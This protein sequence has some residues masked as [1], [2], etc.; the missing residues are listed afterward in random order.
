MITVILPAFNEQDSIAQ[1]VYRVRAVCDRAGLHDADI[2]VVDDGSSDE[3]LSDALNAGAIVVRH[4]HNLGYG[5]ALKA[6][7]LRSRHDTIVI[8][9]ADL[10]YPV[11]SLPELLERYSQGFDMV[12][13]ARTGE[14]YKESV[15]KGHLRNVLKWLVEFT[16]GRKI[17]DINSGFRVFSK[18]TVSSHL[19]HLCDTFSFTTSMTL[20]Y[21]MTGK[22]VDYVPIE[23][24]RRQGT[25]KVRLLRDSLRTMQY[26]VQAI[27]FYNP[28]KLFVLMSWISLAAAAPFLLIGLLSG[29]MFSSV[30]GSALLVLCG[31][32]FSIGLVADLI[33]QVG[34]QLRSERQPV[35]KRQMFSAMPPPAS[36]MSMEPE[37]VEIAAP[38]VNSRDGVYR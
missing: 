6:G 16:A 34:L 22:F 8:V 13:G 4:P 11:E 7:I 21:M 25:T 20:A 27:T 12:V 36:D 23:Y 29:S 35:E 33:R 26:I 1:S 17:P 5:R 15:L 31:L 9:D 18:Q 19:D 37:E 32:I 38:V 2:M 28:I 3:T 24:H 30:L 10:T 14:Y